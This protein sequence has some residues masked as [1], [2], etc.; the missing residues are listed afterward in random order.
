MQISFYLL[1]SSLAFI[2]TNDLLNLLNFYLPYNLST[3]ITFHSVPPT[4]V[5]RFEFGDYQGQL[6]CLL[7]PLPS[8]FY[9]LPFW[10]FVYKSFI[11]YFW[12]TLSVALDRYLGSLPVVL[13]KLMKPEIKFKAPVCTQSFQLSDPFLR[14]PPSFLRLFYFFLLCIYLYLHSLN[15][16]NSYKLWTFLKPLTCISLHLL[17]TSTRQYYEHPSPFFSSPLSVF[18]LD[19]S[20]FHYS[21]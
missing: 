1:Y 21:R 4:L 6:L 5:D 3:N 7:R 19:L 16:G 12:T 17:D 2:K 11:L 8:C 20:F 13:K 14:F 18:S 10:S 9:L 15:H